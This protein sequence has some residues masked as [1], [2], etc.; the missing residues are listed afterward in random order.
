MSVELGVFKA[1]GSLRVGEISAS[2][3][4]YASRW[5]SLIASL[6]RVGQP[7][8]RRS[9]LILRR[10]AI[11]I[12]PRRAGSAKS[13]RSPMVPVGRL[14]CANHCFDQFFSVFT[15]YDSGVPWAGHS[16]PQR[17][18]IRCR[19]AAQSPARRQV[20]GLVTWWW[21]L[22]GADLC[23]TGNARLVL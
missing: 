20:R 8:L 17:P 18:A 16:S 3:F 19:A 22:L 6:C 2:V 4:S 9:V 23:K 1:C 21:R 5:K 12:H 11:A 13:L 10:M 15:V 7:R 14:G